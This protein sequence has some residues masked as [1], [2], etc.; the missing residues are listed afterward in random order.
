LIKSITRR[1]I[2]PLVGIE[3]AGRPLLDTD[4]DVARQKAV[5]DLRQFDGISHRKALQDAYAMLLPDRSQISQQLFGY[6]LTCP[7]RPSSLIG[8]LAICFRAVRTSENGDRLSMKYATVRPYAD[9]EKAACRCRP[10]LKG[11][12]SRSSPAV[13]IFPPRRLR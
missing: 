8:P 3:V 7:Y 12:G 4:E 1:R 6:S 13:N 10:Q 9:L 11:Q 2:A 5:S